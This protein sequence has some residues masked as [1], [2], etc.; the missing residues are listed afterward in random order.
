MPFEYEEMLEKAKKELPDIK[1]SKERFELPKVVGHLQG[2]KTVVTN[3]AQICSLLRRPQE[4][5]L[6][7]LQRE[8]ATPATVEGPRLVLGRKISSSIINEKIE[9]Y[10]QDFVLCKECQKPDT[11]LIKEGRFLF[12]KCTA[13]GAKHPVRG[14]I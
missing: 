3:F 2:N 8:L 10:C 6:K 14:K 9:R 5:L 11:Q 7:Y 4:Q 12:M 1:E 13:C